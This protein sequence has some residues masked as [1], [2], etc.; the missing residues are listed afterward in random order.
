MTGLFGW[1]GLPSQPALETKINMLTLD[2]LRAASAKGDLT[3][4]TL[5]VECE[6]FFRTGKIDAWRHELSQRQI[7]TLILRCG[8]VM[9]VLGYNP[10]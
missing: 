10:E 1:T 6:G 3:C 9:R 7:E 2:T 5:P 4:F 8:E